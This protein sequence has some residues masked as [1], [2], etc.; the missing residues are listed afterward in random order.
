LAEFQAMQ[1][2]PDKRVPAEV[3]GKARAIILLDRTKAGFVF[4]YQGG[5][6]VAMVKDKKGHRLLS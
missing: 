1:A 4:A 6:G 5:G 3:L 2:R